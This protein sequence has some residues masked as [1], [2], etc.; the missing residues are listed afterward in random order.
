MVVDR[1]SSWPRSP[2]RARVCVCVQERGRAK[3]PS[4]HP[5]DNR[6]VVPMFT[7]DS[8]RKFN[9]AGNREEENTPPPRD[10]SLVDSMRDW[11]L[12]VH[13]KRAVGCKWA[14][15]SATFGRTA[16]RTSLIQ[17]GLSSQHAHPDAPRRIL[18][19]HAR[20]HFPIDRH[21]SPSPRRPVML[22]GAGAGAAAVVGA[23]GRRV[24]G[25]QHEVFAL[26]RAILRA[27]K[28]K[29]AGTF[30]LARAQFR[31]DVRGAWPR[32]GPPSHAPRSPPL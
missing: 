1:W 26:Y 19:P 31:Q 32:S 17:F 9:D 10:G 30:Q 29:D 24:S 4:I 8:L 28:R 3:P 13:I 22:A 18:N 20:P 27:A 5:L 12:P 16:A 25:L 15:S 23:A 11:L 21:A 14:A 2:V 7:H 6:I